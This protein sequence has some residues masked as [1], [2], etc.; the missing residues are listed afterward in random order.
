MR[1]IYYAISDLQSNGPSIYIML[2]EKKIANII[3]T[4]FSV[5]K[6]SQEHLGVIGLQKSK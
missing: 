3:I 2:T 1:S 5:S 6:K 4:S